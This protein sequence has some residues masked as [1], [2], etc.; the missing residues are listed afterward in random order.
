MVLSL[1]LSS[2]ADLFVELSHEHLHERVA[3]LGN[4]L[5]GVGLHHASKLKE[6]LYQPPTCSAH[7]SV[8]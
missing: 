6:F 7:T 5:A 8:R 4:A 3:L 2:T 1:L